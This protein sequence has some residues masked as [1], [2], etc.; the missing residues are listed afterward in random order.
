MLVLFLIAAGQSELFVISHERWTTLPL[1]VAGVSDV[2][3]V[4]YE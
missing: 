3:P 1:L 2:L 4:S